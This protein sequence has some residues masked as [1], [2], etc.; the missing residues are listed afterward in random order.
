MSKGEQRGRRTHVCPWW[1]AYLFDNPVR[2]RLHDAERILGPYVGPGMKVADIGCGLGYFSVELARLVG[3]EGRVLSVDVQP[4]M[5]KQVSRRARR[6]GVTERIELRACSA[7]RLAER[8]ALD[9]ALAFWSAH[10]VPDQPGLYRAMAA[11][12]KAGGRLLVVEPLRH[13][14]SSQFE[15]AVQHAIEQ[16]LSVVRRPGIWLSR[17]V[18]YVKPA[19]DT[20]NQ[21]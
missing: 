11:S 18:L 21:A 3:P 10:E 6:A 9:F 2:R 17:A 16:G 8:G 13:V 5:L 14:P 15:R 20:R 19:I 4:A 1:L 7:E 12:L